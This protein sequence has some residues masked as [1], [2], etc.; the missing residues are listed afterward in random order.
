MN[1]LVKEAVEWD[2]ADLIPDPRN[3]NHHDDEHIAIIA[4]R[5]RDSGWYNPILADKKTKMIV[6]GHGRWEA[7]KLLSLSKVPVI[8]KDYKSKKERDLDRIADNMSARES[9]LLMPEIANVILEYDDG[10][11]QPA[12]WGMKVNSLNEL[13]LKAPPEEIKEEQD[14]KEFVTCPKCGHIF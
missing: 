13:M 4:K 2:I 3:E 10:T 5:I 12:D 11:L 1:N 9:T 14:S 6:A 8:F 7:A